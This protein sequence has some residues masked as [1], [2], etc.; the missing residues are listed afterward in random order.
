MKNIFGSVTLAAVVTFGAAFAH[1]IIHENHEGAHAEGDGHMVVEHDGHMDH[2]H[3]GHLH[4]QHEGH[5]DDHVIWI[6]DAN[7]VGE[8]KD[9]HGFEAHVH[10]DDDGHMIVQHADH[11][12]HLH[13]G[14]LHHAHGDHVDEHGALKIVK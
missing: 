6:S 10:T 12:D 14:H 5:V 7:P 13:D 8:Q 3:D 2:L 4:H 9:L 11:L 1:G